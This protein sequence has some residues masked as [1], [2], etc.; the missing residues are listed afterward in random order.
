VK[1][2][3]KI[4]FPISLYYKDL[5]E[6]EP[7]NAGIIRQDVSKHRHTALFRLNGA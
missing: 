1:Q 7:S 5:A 6:E 2:I 3:V 4:V